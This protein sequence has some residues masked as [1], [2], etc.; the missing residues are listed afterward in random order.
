V[1]SGEAGSV[2]E[3]GVLR[4]G[5]LGE[6]RAERQATCGK[7][8]AAM[9]GQRNARRN[10]PHF[11]QNFALWSPTPESCPLLQLTLTGLTERLLVLPEA[12]RV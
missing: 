6:G 7:L 4:R 1:E 3:R 11:T 10:G 5:R 8:A 12:E 2:L 9:L